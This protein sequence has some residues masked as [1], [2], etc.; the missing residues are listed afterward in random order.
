MVGQGLL[1]LIA[2]EAGT[3]SSKSAALVFSL[4]VTG[5]WAS[6]GAATAGR[7][8]RGPPLP[9]VLPVAGLRP[10]RCALPEP[11][12]GLRR[13]YPV[14]RA[15]GLYKA[16][17]DT[18]LMPVSIALKLGEAPHLAGIDQI[19]FGA[20][21]TIALPSDLRLVD[22]PNPVEMLGTPRR[23]MASVY[24]SRVGPGA[25]AGTTDYRLEMTA[26]VWEIKAATPRRSGLSVACLYFHKQ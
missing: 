21:T 14:R 4:L 11:A 5:A 10:S 9:M 17:G 7:V 15:H 6:P 3:D 22:G 19:L 1:R 24:H 20:E 12:G 23:P 18:R 8:H 25:Q 2:T 13:T 16:Y 26:S